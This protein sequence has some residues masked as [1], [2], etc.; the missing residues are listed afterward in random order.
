MS[1]NL[2][3]WAC[4]FSGCDGGNPNSNIWLCG[5]EPAYEHATAMER[6]YYYKNGLPEE[7]ENGEHK[8][9][10]NYNFFTDESMSFPFNLAFSK[11][12]SVIQN[13]N[14]SDM[15][16][17]TG[18]ILK[19]NLS[20]I[21]FNKDD[22][23]FWGESLVEATGIK[24]KTEFVEYLNTL[25]RFTDI[26]KQHS[27]KLIVC[28]GNGYRDD[29]LRGF[30]GNEKIE[31]KYETVKPESSNKNQ[32]NRY[33]YHAKHNDTV[34]VVTPFSTSTNGLNSDQLLQSV[35]ERIKELLV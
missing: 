1:V 31:F 33:I 5:I 18:E 20:P 35:G 2:D 17:N 29:F 11:L 3:E 24:T 32:N 15:K 14:V 7:I 9:N 12:Y 26:T 16:N 34:L 27:P 13:G 23:S 19:L 8:L 21:A 22:D 6:E 25:N 30:F 28:I 10:R 4:S